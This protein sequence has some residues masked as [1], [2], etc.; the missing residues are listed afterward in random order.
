[1]DVAEFQRRTTERQRTTLENLETLG[2]GYR[3]EARYV[4][5][6]QPLLL[7]LEDAI[8]MLDTM[9]LIVSLPAEGEP[10]NAEVRGCALLP[11]P[12]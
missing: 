9:G 11:L 5:G 8:Y 7:V 2:I 3:V 4:L 6:P 1:M 12:S 10:E